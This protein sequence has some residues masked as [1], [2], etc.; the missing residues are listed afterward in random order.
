MR[1]WRNC[2]AKQRLGFYTGN[3]LKEQFGAN[4][5]FDEDN[6]PNRYMFNE[7]QLDVFIDEVVKKLG[8]HIVSISEA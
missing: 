6:E 3:E 7:K 5:M 8:L 4:L 1:N 2:R